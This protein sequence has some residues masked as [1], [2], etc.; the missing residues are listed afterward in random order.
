M[1]QIV[2]SAFAES[3]QEALRLAHQAGMEGADWLELRLDR[4]PL[5]LDLAPVVA[6]APLPVLV[7]C[8]R[9][10]DGGQ[11]RGTLAERRALLQMALSAG[12]AGLDLEL[13]EPWAPP[14]GATKLKLLVRSFH[15]LT[16]VPKNLAEVQRRLFKARGTLAKIVVTAHDMADAAPVFELLAATDQATMPTVAFAMGRTC[17]PSR[18][19]AAM[20][21][22]PFVYGCLEGS[23]PTASGQLSVGQLRGLFRARELSKQT[24]LFALLGMPALQSL[25][26]WLH[27]R[28]FRQVGQDALYLPIETYRPHESL[29][30]LR[31]FS[32][33]GVSVT[34]PYKEVLA[35]T[36]NCLAAS[37]ERCGVVNTITFDARGFATGHNTDVVGVVEA[38]RSAGVAPSCGASAV[39]LGA[40]GAARAGALALRE[41]GFA[42][43]LLARSLERVRAFAEAASVRLGSLSSQVLTDLAPQ[44][45]V[46]AT[47]VG[48][49][50]QEEHRV[51]PDYAFARGVT[52][53][54]MVYQPRWTRLLRD[55]VAAGGTA[56]P[57][58]G[59]F[60][61]QAVAQAKL[62][63]GVDLPVADL[64]NNLAGTAAGD[65]STLLPHATLP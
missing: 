53:L 38:L 60:L 2:A 8:R 43:T 51:L 48:S 52:V 15:S 37:A 63:T 12:V 11:F 55:V 61:H 46:H 56:V 23:E 6:S 7:T 36:C 18:L 1:A 29:A 17:W 40:G 50:G 19:L 65:S 20:L 62:F 27:N 22:A 33:G 59:M 28:V 10:E 9:P 26:P 3:Q 16:G 25:G 35:E 39:V 32:L 47:P 31:G 64:R 24:R 49:V 41:L 30:M 21:G 54:D 5:T 45:I 44:V 58:A 57:G 42:V 34:A 4:W 13:D 14:L